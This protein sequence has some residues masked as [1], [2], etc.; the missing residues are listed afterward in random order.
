MMSEIFKPVALLALWTMI[1]WLWMYA[2]RIPAMQKVKDL[3]MPNMVGGTGRTLDDVLPQKVQW[4][5]HNYN[6]L[7][8]Q[9]TVFYA[10]AIL[11]GVMGAGDGLNAQL[12]WAYVALR[13]AHSLFQ[14]L[15]NRV[16]IRFTLF[17]LASLCLIALVVHA[18]AIAFAH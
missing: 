6:H 17:L 10:V 4:V 7:H 3:D 9:P 2:T 8:E 15:V 5:A 11:L 18:A 16:V 12:A 1:M 13:I 14:A